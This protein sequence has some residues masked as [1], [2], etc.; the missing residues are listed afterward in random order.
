MKQL[1]DSYGTP[2]EAGDRIVYGVRGSVDINMY[3]ALV[4]SVTPEGSIKAVVEGSDQDWRIKSGYLKK[5]RGVTLTATHNI[6]V[7]AKWVQDGV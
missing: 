3:K 7:V 1:V 4:S 6:I 5:Y 2:I